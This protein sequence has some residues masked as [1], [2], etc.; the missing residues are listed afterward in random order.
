[1]TSVAWLWRLITGRLDQPGL[2]INCMVRG[3]NRWK[4]GGFG[5]HVPMVVES[6]P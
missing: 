2:F 4:N 5:H 6:N 3:A 1:M